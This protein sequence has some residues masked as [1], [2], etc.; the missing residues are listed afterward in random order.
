MSRF[1]ARLTEYLELRP[2]FG[3]LPD[4]DRVGEAS[5]QGHAPFVTM[6]LAVDGGRVREARFEAAGCG[7][8]IGAAAALTELVPGKTLAE[9]AALEVDDLI[10][11]IDGLPFDKRYCAHVVLAAL[12]AALDDQSGADTASS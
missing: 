12:K 1:S 5:L 6:Y 2:N 8:T 3:K 7:V 11:A 10:A 9:C 4:A